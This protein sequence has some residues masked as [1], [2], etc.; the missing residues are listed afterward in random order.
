MLIKNPKIIIIDLRAEDERSDI[1]FDCISMPYYEI[2]QNLHFLLNKNKIIFYCTYGI[3]SMNVI[4]YLKN[5]Y[6]MENLYSLVL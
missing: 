6:K 4:N 1:G 2:S 3:H 5:V